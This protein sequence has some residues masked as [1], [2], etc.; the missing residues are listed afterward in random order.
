MTLRPDGTMYCKGCDRLRPRILFWKGPGGRHHVLCS[1]CR[2]LPKKILGE[3]TPHRT[4]FIVGYGRLFPDGIRMTGLTPVDRETAKNIG[5][6]FVHA[7][8]R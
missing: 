5:E 4:A 8:R 1:E 2:E 6:A 7:M 3:P